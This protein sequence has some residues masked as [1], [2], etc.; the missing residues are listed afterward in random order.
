MINDFLNSIALKAK[1]EI[2]INECDYQKDGLWYCGKCNTPKECNFNSPLFG[3]I[4]RVLCKCEQEK[5]EEEKKKLEFEQISIKKEH[6]FEELIRDKIQNIA[7]LKD[8]FESDLY[9]N[10]KKSIMFR[11]YCEK[12]KEVKTNNIGMIISGSVGTGKTFYANCIAN[13]IRQKYRDLCVTITSKQI[14]E[15]SIFDRADYIKKFIYADLLVIDDLGAERLTEASQEAIFDLIDERKKVEKPTIVTT[16]LTMEDFKNPHSTQQSRIFDR[17]NE[18]CGKNTVQM[19]GISKRQDIA[20]N[21]SKELK[22]II[23]N[24]Q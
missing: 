17:I 13:E 23:F 1:K 12:W 14:T 5:E 15:L 24:D 7:D 21:K 3:G 6:I 22:N 10:S 8:T 9:P 16:N 20:R 18:M 11:K 4:H 19:D 2:L